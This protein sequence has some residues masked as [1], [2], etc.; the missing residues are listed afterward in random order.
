[1]RSILLFFGFLCSGFFRLMRD[2]VSRIS[3]PV[4]K[5]VFEIVGNVRA[6]VFKVSSIFAKAPCSATGGTA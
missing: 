2:F 6:Q 5:P 1:M 3:E 4:F